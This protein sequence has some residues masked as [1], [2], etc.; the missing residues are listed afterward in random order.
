MK[1]YLPYIWSPM[2]FGFAIYSYYSHPHMC[3]GP[4]SKL[5]NEMWFMWMIMGFMSLD[6]YFQKCFK[7]RK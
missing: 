5:V 7:C 1:N 4:E 3:G 6:A 2:C